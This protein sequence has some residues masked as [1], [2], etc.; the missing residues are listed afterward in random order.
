MMLIAQKIR[1][2]SDF[3][4]RAYWLPKS[5]ESTEHSKKQL[6]ICSVSPTF[7]K[8][9][10]PGHQSVRGLSLEQLFKKFYGQRKNK[11]QTQKTQENC[12]M[13][14]NA[15]AKIYIYFITYFILY[16]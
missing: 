8:T 11:T 2:G 13:L 3:M 14:K 10:C 1:K 16:I 9:T 7:K 6:Q 5:L 12:K 15:K 4:P